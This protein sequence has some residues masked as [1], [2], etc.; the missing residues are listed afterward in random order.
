[1]HYRVIHA[2]F[3]ERIYPEQTFISQKGSLFEIQYHM[4]VLTLEVVRK[5]A[6]ERYE[7]TGDIT[8][9]NKGE[10]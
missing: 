5:R 1:M 8:Y 9:L 7:F 10:S 3:K 6:F 4:H 2:I